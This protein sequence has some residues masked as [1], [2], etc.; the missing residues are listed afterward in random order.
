MKVAAMGMFGVLLLTAGLSAQR[1]PT[2]SMGNNEIFTGEITDSLCPDTRHADAIKNEKN[3]VLTCVKFEGAE[4]VLYNEGTKRIYKLDDQQQPMPFA[5]QEV[6][7]S[8]RY[9][10]ASN[11]IHVIRITPKITDAGL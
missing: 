4:F 2:I 9:D 10:K 6:M 1:N 5:G 3:C 8:G 7:V 11:A